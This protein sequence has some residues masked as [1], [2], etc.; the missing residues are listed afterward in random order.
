MILQ[1]ISADFVD[2]PVCDI[3]LLYKP[4]TDTWEGVK[5]VPDDIDIWELHREVAAVPKIFI[6]YCTI[7]AE[8][9]TFYIEEEWQG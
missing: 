5:E 9:I 1:I 8:F 3:G 7:D 2:D 6:D 4:R